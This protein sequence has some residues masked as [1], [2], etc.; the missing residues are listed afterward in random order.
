MRTQGPPQA[1][2]RRSPRSKLPR[3]RVRFVSDAILLGIVLLCKIIGLLECVALLEGPGPLLLATVVVH[4][5]LHNPK[6]HALRPH[7][8][9][10]R[11][12][13]VGEGEAITKS[14][15]QRL[16][17]RAG[18]PG[19]IFRARAAFSGRGTTGQEVKC[20]HLFCCAGLSTTLIPVLFDSDRTQRVFLVSNLRPP[21]RLHSPPLVQ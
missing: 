5:A 18:G 11:S 6:P 2:K 7:I 10:R 1:P 16:S 9:P 17:R 4:T 14:R 15:G 20:S 19:V 12:D 21:R 8:L 13:R 3:V